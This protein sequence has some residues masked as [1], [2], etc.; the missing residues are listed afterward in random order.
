MASKLCI[1]AHPDDEII[2]LGGELS[3]SPDDWHVVCVTN[4]DNEERSAEFERTMQDIGCT[5][6]IWPLYDEWNVPLDEFALS[7]HL[8]RLFEK[9]WDLVVTHD[10]NGDTGYEHPHHRQVHE[11]VKDKIGDLT[12]LFCFCF[13]EY[14]SPEILRRKLH[15]LSNYKSQIKKYDFIFIPMLEEYFFREGYRRYESNN[16]RN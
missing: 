15:L 3:L 7:K 10:Q 13:D 6:E 5:F 4:G 12:K 16:S 11:A 1:V 2:F 8:I 9:D 14:L